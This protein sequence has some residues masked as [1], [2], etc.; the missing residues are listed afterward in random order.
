MPASLVPTI[1]LGKLHA[2][3]WIYL[4]LIEPIEVSF[5]ITSFRGLETEDHVGGN[6]LEAL[7]DLTANNA[8]AEFE[9]TDLS[10]NSVYFITL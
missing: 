3:S 6:L 5:A 10:Y 1:K 7:P 2:L 8:E 9:T 4:I